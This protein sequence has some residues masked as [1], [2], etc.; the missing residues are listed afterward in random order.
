MINNCKLAHLRFGSDRIGSDRF[1]L[2]AASLEIHFH[3]LQR[4]FC[5]C[6]VVLVADR[7]E[8]KATNIAARR[9]RGSSD[10]GGRQTGMQLQGNKNNNN[11]NNINST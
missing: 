2:P 1:D 7:A 11:S 10:G 9:V 4:S 5:K 8:V 6:C 3:F